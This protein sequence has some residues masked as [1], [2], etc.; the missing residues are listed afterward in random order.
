M[1]Q[2][3]SWFNYRS[4]DVTT[5]RELWCEAFDLTKDV[6]IFGNPFFTVLPPCATGA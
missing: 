3:P 1:R 4:D 2:R 6:T 5:N